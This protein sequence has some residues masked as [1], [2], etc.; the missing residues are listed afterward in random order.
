MVAERESS[1]S[2]QVRNP[3]RMPPISPPIGMNGYSV[4]NDPLYVEMA[5]WRLGHLENV[6]TL[7]RDLSQ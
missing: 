4:D 5:N 3:E 1:V 2:D 7:E 6:R